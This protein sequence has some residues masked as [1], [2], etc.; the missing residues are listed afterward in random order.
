MLLSYQS[1]TCFSYHDPPLLMAIRTALVALIAFMPTNPNGA[2]GSLDYKK[3]ERR[4]LVI[5][6]HGA[7]PKFGTSEHQ[8]LIDE[9]HQYMLSKVP[10]VPQLVAQESSDEHPTNAEVNVSRRVPA[11]EHGEQPQRPEIIRHVSHRLESLALRPTSHSSKYSVKGHKVLEIE[12][13]GT[14]NTHKDVD[15]LPTFVP[16]KCNNPT[17]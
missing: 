5:K 13:F 10:P 7:A 16:L 15:M 12:V 2:L 4:C 8:R 17:C 14:S 9:I 3:E 1:L 11:A 6:S